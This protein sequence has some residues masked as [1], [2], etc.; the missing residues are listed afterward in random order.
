MVS[1]LRRTLVISHNLQSANTATKGDVGWVSCSYVMGGEAEPLSWVGPSHWSCS[2]TSHSS[3]ESLATSSWDPGAHCSKSCH[4]VKGTSHSWHLV[5]WQALSP[6]YQFNNVLGRVWKTWQPFWV[7]PVNWE[8]R[9][10]VLQG[11]RETELPEALEEGFLRLSLLPVF[12]NW[13]SICH[14]GEETA[15]LTQAVSINKPKHCLD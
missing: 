1:A 4:S 15:T 2:W 8:R 13:P 3:P 10:V 5:S 6:F 12:L 14:L 7:C 11:K 9:P